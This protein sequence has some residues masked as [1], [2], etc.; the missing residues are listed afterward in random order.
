M[1][2][3]VAIPALV[4]VCLAFVVPGS[5]EIGRA[6]KG[7]EV[8]LSMLAPRGGPLHNAFKKLG[9][10][11]AKLTNGA[12][13]IRIYPA[14]VAGDERDVVR[15][16]QVGQI[17]GAINTT[18]GTSIIEPQVAILDAPGLIKTYAQMDAVREHTEKDFEQMLLKKNVKLLTW[19]EAGQYRLFA[20]GEIRLVADLKKHRAWLWPDSYILK[21]LYREARASAVPLGSTDVYAALQTGMVDSLLVS[22]Y[23]AVQM[24][25]HTKLD[26]VSQ[27]AS[28]VLLMQWI[29]N[30]SKWDQLPDNVK[31]V[32]LDELPAT[33]QQAKLDSRKGD[34]DAYKALLQRGYK[35]V[36][37]TPAEDADWDNLFDRVNK[38]L[39]GRLWPAALY[40]KIKAI[41][42]KIPG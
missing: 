31:K 33:R 32:I 42:S 1:F 20:K 35:A 41:V 6:Q 5:A 2:H 15:K 28:G 12:W 4:A 10:K 7:G 25:W 34:E 21:E 13:Q 17:D 8:K 27:R 3:K 39:T 24:R 38:K 16:M 29:M 37:S 9:D 40:D 19:W 18:V 23:A 30:K 14:G 22:A 11:I 26:H 36:V